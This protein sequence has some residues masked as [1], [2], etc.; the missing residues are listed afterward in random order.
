MVLSLLQL[1]VA[2]VVLEAQ[3]E[4]LIK[5]QLILRRS[6]RLTTVDLVSVFSC[7]KSFNENK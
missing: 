7:I 5:S 6:I 4:L 2:M 1:G 3:C